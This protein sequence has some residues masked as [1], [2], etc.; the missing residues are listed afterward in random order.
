MTLTIGFVRANV[1]GDTQGTINKIGYSIICIGTKFGKSSDAGSLSRAYA[2]TGRIKD[3][4]IQG[5]NIALF[6]FPGLS[7][8][9]TPFGFT[10]TAS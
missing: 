6:T 10:P 1:G 8:D 3:N 2:R 9:D 7:S 4:I 5:D